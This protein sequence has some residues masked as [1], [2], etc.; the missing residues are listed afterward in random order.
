[1]AGKHEKQENVGKS[2][3]RMLKSQKVRNG[4]EMLALKG[5][6]NWN[7]ILLN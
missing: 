7:T 5:E 3:S 4:V 6:T 1:M 2:E